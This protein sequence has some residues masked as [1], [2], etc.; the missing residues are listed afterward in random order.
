[1][2]N[3]LHKIIVI[4]CVI[5]LSVLIKTNAQTTCEWRLAKP[6]YSNVDPDGAGLATG[7][8]TFTLQVHTVSGTIPNV[9]GISTGWSWQSANAM[10]PTGSPCGMNSVT[11]PANIIMS[12]AFAGFTYNNVDECSG[13]VNF[14]NGSQTFDRRSSGTVDGGTIIL[15]TTFIDVFT[16]TLWTLGTTNPEGGYVVINSGDMGSP[17]VFTTYAIS[18]ALA[19]E[20]TVNS[21]TFTNA[22]ALGSASLPVQFT[23]FEAGCTNNGALVSW[24]TGS[25]FN[26]NYFELQRSTNGNEWTIVATIKA[27]GNSSTGRTYQQLDANGGPAYYRIKQVDIDG[28]FIYT[29]II[30]TNCSPKSIDMV[31]YPVPARDILNVVIQSDK[32]LKT[33][34]LLVDGIGKIVRKIDATLFNGSNT[35]L[36]NLKGLASGEYIIRSNAPGVE[37][38][39]KFNIIR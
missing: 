29:S 6:T 22:L 1:M 35:F 8:V 13:S 9:T 21:L 23:K 15:T 11:Q 20:F 5:I 12:P 14:S 27:A 7:S 26:S 17:G 18:D 37:L 3:Y 10:L 32:S 2:K 4:T 28:H 33:Q 36:F 31:I 39:K 24:S 30:R 25:E 19:D 38:N 16:V 34:L